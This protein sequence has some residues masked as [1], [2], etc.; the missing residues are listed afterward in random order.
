MPERPS[1][2]NLLKI[3]HE[4][5][6]TAEQ[7]I[8]ILDK[9]NEC[10]V[11]HE[12]FMGFMHKWAHKKHQKLSEKSEKFAEKAFTFID[13]NHDGVVD[14]FEMHYAMNEIVEQFGQLG[15]KAEDIYAFSWTTKTSTQIWN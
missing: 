7:A 13:D 8:A 15:E 10:T 1:A 3:L 6:L 11:N 9:S 5:G 14:P 4:Q 2:V 12:E